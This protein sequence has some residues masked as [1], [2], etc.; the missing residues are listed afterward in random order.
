MP[1]KLIA[2]RKH[3]DILQSGHFEITFANETKLDQEVLLFSS[4]K[5][6]AQWL[7]G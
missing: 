5:L 3:I 2:E 6:A 7:S 4:S 1:E